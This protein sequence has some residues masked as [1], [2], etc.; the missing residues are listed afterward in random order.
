MTVE[1]QQ[2]GEDRLKKYLNGP[3][4]GLIIMG[5]AY[6][7]WWFAGP[8]A[9]ESI[10]LDPRWIHNW[11]FALIIFNVGL[12]WYHKSPI[13]RFL[14]MIQA[15]MLPVTASGS[16]NT[17]ICTLIV[18]MIFIGWVSIVIIEKMKKISLLNAK[19]S[20]RGK[21]WFDMHTMIIAWILIAHMGLMFFVVR[22]P[23][24]S[25]LY[26]IDN[27]A[28]FLAN[29]PPE[30]LEL[31]TW[32]YD[33][34]LFAFLLVVIWEQ[35]KLG[36]NLKNKS[37]PRYSFYVVILVMGISLLALLIQDLTIGFNWVDK[38]YG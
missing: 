18:A 19:L 27:Q 8:W 29:L 17:A 25:S 7:L 1:I 30:G 13:S 10:A 34:G 32:V 6:I 3:G 2:D 22:F 23:L 11:A 21:L 9:W 24:E 12:A 14:A 28:G 26:R 36:Y 20:E 35:Y 38:F 31:S 33:I 4:T 16:F 15:M 37:W 5:F